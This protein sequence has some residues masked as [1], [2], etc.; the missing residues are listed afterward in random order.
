MA[1]AF[2]GPLK[3][4]REGEPDTGSEPATA[5]TRARLETLQ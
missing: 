3:P 5:L 2:Y 1:E 4:D